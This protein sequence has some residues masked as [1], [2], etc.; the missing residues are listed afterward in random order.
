[1]E[2][3]SGADYFRWYIQNGRDGPGPLL[4][5][6]PLAGPPLEGPPPTSMTER[7]LD[8][9]T[10]P[11]VA[12]LPLGATSRL[13][14]VTTVRSFDLIDVPPPTAASRGRRWA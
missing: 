5:G 1:M 13:V 9:F 10:S 4:A 8:S 12:P 11:A 7:Q 3:D 14:G 2:D 6:P